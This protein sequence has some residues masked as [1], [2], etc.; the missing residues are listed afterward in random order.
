MPVNTLKPSEIMSFLKL[1]HRSATLLVLASLALVGCGTQFK[2][3]ADEFVRTQPASAWGKQPPPGHR[4]VEQTYVKSRLKDPE[5]VRF[6][7]LEMQRVVI[8]ASMTDPKIVPVWASRF[9]VNAKNAF[10]GYTGF[11][12]WNFYYRE[13][14]L[15]A[16][17][18]PE[19]GRQYV[20][21]AK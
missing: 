3:A 6:Q 20:K 21:T 16:I 4:L 15:F 12:E 8:S 14:E 5:S 2:N 9:L 10:G 18:S 17:E 11:K 13:G 19:T 1:T 7:D